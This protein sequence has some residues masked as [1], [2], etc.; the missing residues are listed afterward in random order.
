MICEGSPVG[1][2]DPFLSMVPWCRP[3]RHLD[4]ERSRMARA[5]LSR[6]GGD[7]AET[8]DGK[9]GR[10]ERRRKTKTGNGGLRN[11]ISAILIGDTISVNGC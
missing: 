9:P 4:G 5:G 8:M 6:P 11:F 2:G 3:E 1:T 10:I 7:R